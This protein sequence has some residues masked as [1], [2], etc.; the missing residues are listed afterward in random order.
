MGYKARKR[1]RC[2]GCSGSAL[3]TSASSNQLCYVQA[4]Q[5]VYGKRDSETELSGSRAVRFMT[6]SFPL[7]PLPPAVAEAGPAAGGPVRDA[8]GGAGDAPPHVRG[9][10]A[11]VQPP[12]RR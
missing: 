4:K 9:V 6:D 11:Q 7:V 3:Q 8:V 10:P 1:R 2:A 5:E 12:R